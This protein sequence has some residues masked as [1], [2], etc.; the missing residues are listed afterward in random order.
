MSEAGRPL[1]RYISADQIGSLGKLETYLCSLAMR[2][3]QGKGK[4]RM[5]QA[6]KSCESPCAYGK[7]WVKMLEDQQK[8]MEEQKK[9]ALEGFVPVKVAK[10]P[11]PKPGTMTKLAKLEK[12][13]EE[14][15]REMEAAKECARGAQAEL[16]ESQECRKALNARIQELEMKLQDHKGDEKRLEEA[17]KMLGRTKAELTETCRVLEM[18]T[19][20]RDE[21]EQEN[22]KAQECLAKAERKLLETVE[23]LTQERRTVMA[24]K[25]RLWDMEHPEVSA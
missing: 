20:E 3:V 10:K 23:A 13:N 15:R 7:R 21:I 18:V 17:G 14:L 9:N 4:V 8:Q 11:E 25:A 6:C 22:D 12:E 19:Q 2:K 16:E 24:L 5:P 1:L